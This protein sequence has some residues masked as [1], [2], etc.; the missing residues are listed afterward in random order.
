MH[1]KFFPAALAGGVAMLTLLQSLYKQ[2][3]FMPTGGIKLD[4]LGTFLRCANVFC[5]GGSWLCPEKL[6]TDNS[7]DQIEELVVTAAEF[8]ADLAEEG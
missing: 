6:M 3:S 1:L 5:C 4:N 8:M 7:W 2:A